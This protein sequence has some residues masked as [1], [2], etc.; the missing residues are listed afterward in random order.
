MSL[1]YDLD[2]WTTPEPHPPA[3]PPGVRSVVPRAGR[4]LHL[5]RAR[6]VEPEFEAHE[7]AWFLSAAKTPPPPVRVPVLALLFPPV[8]TGVTLLAGL[9]GLMV[10]G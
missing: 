2:A 6:R 7:H 1:A 3:P 9:L 10:L 8:A 5:P 4:L